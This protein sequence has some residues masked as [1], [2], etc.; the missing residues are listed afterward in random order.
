MTALI[1]N[2][3]HG[4]RH[5]VGWSNC[6]DFTRLAG[7]ACEHAQHALGRRWNDGKSVGPTPVEHRFEFVLGR[8]HVDVPCGEHRTREPGPEL[9]DEVGIDAE[10]PTS[11]THH[12]KIL[13]EGGVA[14]DFTPRIAAPSNRARDFGTVLDANEGGDGFDVVVP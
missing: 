7:G 5:Q 8:C 12:G 2:L 14:G 1:C 10:R 6:H 13:T 3:F 4:Q 11:G 9:V